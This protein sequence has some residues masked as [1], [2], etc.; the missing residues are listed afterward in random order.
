VTFGKRLRQVRTERG[1]TLRQ[2]AEE[3]GV[4]FTYLS[5][6]ENERV[7][8]TPAAETIRNLA[9]IL[10]V[11]SMEFLKL[12]NKLPK[13]L[14]ALNANVHAR[15]FFDRASQVASPAD[16]EALLELLEDRQSE[17]KL[18]RKEVKREP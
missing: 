12:A 16:W 15:R 14:E 7:P 8:Y 11:D 17:K 13:E 1:L 5:K 2:L 10:T 6:I 18:G 9:R 4:N 3:A